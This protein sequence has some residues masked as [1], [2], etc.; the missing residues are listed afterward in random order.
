MDLYIMHLTKNRHVLPLISFRIPFILLMKK[1][2]EDL[3]LRDLKQIMF[4]ETLINFL[5]DDGA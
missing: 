2:I 3:T 5:T 4:G 1:C